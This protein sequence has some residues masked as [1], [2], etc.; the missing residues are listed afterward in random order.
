MVWKMAGLIEE[1]V[2]QELAGQR[3]GIDLTRFRVFKN[4]SKVQIG[5]SPVL[6]WISLSCNGFRIKL[7]I[8]FM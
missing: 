5:L 4:E 3:K 6:F 2:G 7:K 1:L 8:P